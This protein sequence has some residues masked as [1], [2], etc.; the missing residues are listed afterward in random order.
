MH[1]IRFSF[2]VIYLLLMFLVNDWRNLIVDNLV[3]REFDFVH[4][5]NI[6]HLVE[7][8]DHN[9]HNENNQDDNDDGML[10]E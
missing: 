8:I 4:E 3:D 2:F 6:H 1:A 5:D 7:V 10:Y 9:D